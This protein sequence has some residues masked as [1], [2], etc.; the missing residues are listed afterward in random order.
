MN[1]IQWLFVYLFMAW[2]GAVIVLVW[3]H[4]LIKDYRSRMRPCERCGRD[5]PTLIWDKELGAEICGDCM[6]ETEQALRA[7]RFARK[8]FGGET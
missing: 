5:W 3:Q 2:V 1:G 8:P 4:I 6:A 7:D